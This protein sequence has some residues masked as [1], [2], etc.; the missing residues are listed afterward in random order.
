[1][2]A[3]VRRRGREVRPP[4]STRAFALAACALLVGACATLP[5]PAPIATPVVDAAFDVTGRLSARRGSEG[6]AANF[7]WVHVPGRDAIA[8][9]TP[10]GTTLA[11]LDR[12]AAGASIERSDGSVE[13]AVDATALAER[14]LGFPLPVESLAWWLRAAPR[15]G[16]PHAIEYDASG[17]AAVLR[18][19]GWSI[20]YAWSDDGARPRRLHAT[21][22]DLDVRVVIDAWR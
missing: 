21:Y 9:A 1:M 12:D 17:R 7:D 6:V 14:A 19:D 3:R 20:V 15:P 2:A 22:A 10:M 16:S 5:A 8:L 13:R 11:R 4:R 18:Q